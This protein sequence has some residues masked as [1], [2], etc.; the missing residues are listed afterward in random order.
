MT[1]RGHRGTRVVIIG[2]GIGGL[3]AAVRLA[4]AGCAVTVVEAAPTPGGKMR[5]VPSAAGPVDAGPTVLTLRG[6]FDQVFAAAGTRLEDHLTLIPQPT[7]A[8]HWWPDGS[9]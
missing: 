7:L 4:H 5:T 6:V 2:A 8:R 1:I 3:C 9:T